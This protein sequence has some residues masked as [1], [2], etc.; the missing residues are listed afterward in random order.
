[1]GVTGSSKSKILATLLNSP[2]SKEIPASW[3][4]LHKNVF[5]WADKKA[6]KND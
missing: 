1:M 6:L 4:A 2:C 5:L 3:L